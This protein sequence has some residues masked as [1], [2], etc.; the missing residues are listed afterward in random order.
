MIER[1]AMQLVDIG[2]NLGHKSFAHDLDA[3]LARARAQGITKMMVTGA[4]AQG[5]R[6]AHALALAH[7]GVLFATAGVHPHHASD[8]DAD[9]ETLLRELQAQPQVKA[10]GETGLDYNRNFS[11]RAA[12]LFAFERQLGLAVECGKPL[13]LHQRDA[14]TDFIACM[15]NVRDRIGPAVV[16][17][18]TGEKNEL[19]DYLDR[20][21]HIGITGWICD[22]RRGM[23]LRALVKSIPADRLMLETDAPYLL[24]RNVKPMPSHR[25]NEPMYLA[26]I[27]AEV[28]RDRGEDIAV[29]AANAT[30]TARRFFALPEV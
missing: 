23:H 20:G 15:D 28:A 10:V 19:F 13:F 26:H 18:F 2:A 25:R 11:P 6:A 27:C 5:S 7:P 3:V 4:D 16:H 14:H 17:C 12:Q 1:E 8:F 9:T 24:P 21:F 22:E 29:T 30:A